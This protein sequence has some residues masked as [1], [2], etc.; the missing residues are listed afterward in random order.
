[1]LCPELDDLG[2]G[3]ISVS[4]NFVGGSAYYRCNSGFRQS[5]SSYRTCLL[6]GEWSGTQPTCI[7]EYNYLKSRFYTVASIIGSCG[8]LSSLRYGRVSMTALNV[9]GTATYT[10]YNG[11]SLVGSSTRTCLS[12]GSW[13][14]SQPICNC[15]LNH[16]KFNDF[17]ET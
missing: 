3:S 7:R 6:S 14:G 8:Y 10:C 2:N 15:R 13:S 11:F 16:Y 12:N 17:V 1:M 5:G 9:G 4:S